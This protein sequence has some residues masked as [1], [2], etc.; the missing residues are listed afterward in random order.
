MSRKQ[1]KKDTIRRFA[2]LFGFNIDNKDQTGYLKV[3]E[4]GCM[5]VKNKCD[6][7]K[8]SLSAEPGKGTPRDWCEFFKTEQ[9]VSNW[10]FHPIT[11]VKNYPK[12]F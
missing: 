10:R 2:V 11:V 7:T 8:F 9:D 5:V 3:G 6:A 12:T 4:T 1:T